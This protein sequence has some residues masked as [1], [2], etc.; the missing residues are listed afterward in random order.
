MKHTPTIRFVTAITVL[1]VVCFFMVN[2]VVTATEW[3]HD[4]HTATHQ[5][6]HCFGSECAPTHH[7]LQSVPLPHYI[8]MTY[9]DAQKYFS[10]R[11][12]QY[13][14]P[15]IEPDSPPPRLLA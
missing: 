7:L 1:I 5:M 4:S 15:T 14:G 12:P 13:T 11:Y 6:D 9:T 2:T 10:S 3:N 8:A